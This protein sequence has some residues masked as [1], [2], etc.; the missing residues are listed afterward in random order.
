[1]PPQT[2]EQ[3]GG[4]PRVVGNLSRPLPSSTAFVT[5]SVSHFTVC[6]GS[7]R[8]PGGDGGRKPHCDGPRPA[9]LTK[10]ERRL[11]HHQRGPLGT[12]QH[13]HG[14]CHQRGQGH[15]GEGGCAAHVLPAISGCAPATYPRTK[16]ADVILGLRAHHP[17]H[18]RT[19]DC[20]QPASGRGHGHVT[21]RAGSLTRHPP[22]PS[23]SPSTP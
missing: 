18:P 3:L 9:T 8:K 4:L 15:R 13:P 2:W 7:P 17:S 19:K 23:Y 16:S 21:S 20:A 22:R 14:P 10:L 5:F 6:R 1:M 12:L 11:P